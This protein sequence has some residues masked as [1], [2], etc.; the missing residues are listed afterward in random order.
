MIIAPWSERP[1]VLSHVARAHRVS[2]CAPSG[3]HKHQ[4]DTDTAGSACAHQA[5]EAADVQ[6]IW[7][8]SI[9]IAYRAH[10]PLARR[11]GIT[12]L[13]IRGGARPW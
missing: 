9:G 5:V 3:S 2:A 1:G 13:N 6:G 10:R 8:A 7:Q 11:Y 12:R 4:P